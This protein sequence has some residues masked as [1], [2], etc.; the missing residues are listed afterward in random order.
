MNK[1]N[2]EDYFI[3]GL[4]TAAVIFLLVMAPFGLYKGYQLDKE[5]VK[6]YGDYVKSY[7]AKSANVC[8]EPIQDFK[9]LK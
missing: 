8:E 3:G 4:C 7:T 1:Y 6:L 2:T 5:K 9:G